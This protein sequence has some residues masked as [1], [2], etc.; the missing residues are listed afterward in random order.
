M[1][2]TVEI[3]PPPGI[4]VS[5]VLG[6]VHMWHLRGHRSNAVD[7][8]VR[9]FSAIELLEARKKLTSAV[10]A[11]AD[12][13][14]SR[15]DSDHRSAAEAHA[16]DLLDQFVELD[17]QK[18]LPVIV[19]PSTQLAKVPVST[20]LTSDDVAVSARLE[21]LEKS[22]KLLSD[23]VTSKMSGL[24]TGMFAGARAR[25]NS[26]SGGRG[27]GQ[28]QEGLQGPPQIS[29]TPPGGLAGV[30]S[31]A[32]VANTG[33]AGFQGPQ[34]VG[35]GRVGSDAEKRK[36]EGDQNTFRVPGRQ[37]GRKVAIGKSTVA[38]DDGGE[39]A[40]LEYYVGNTTP[41][42]SPDIIKAVLV[43]CA[44]E[45]QTELQ[46][47]EVTCLTYGLDN[48]R[49]KSWKVKVPYKY[50]ELMEKNE[51]YPE[52]WTYRKFF[53]PRTSS[54]GTGGA[55]KKTRTDDNLVDEILLDL[56][57]PAQA[58]AQSPGQEASTAS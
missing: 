8:I 22:M 31:W 10:G 7:L 45:L 55:I 16:I 1:T 34:V 39:A 12:L 19:V 14:V 44:A 36:W 26:N 53:A 38:V 3:P 27:G 52:G 23:T 33:A 35:R 54:Q 17:R 21:N 58:A 49:T 28:G 2:E 48:P 20:L 43:K 11:D 4:L 25:V 47:I 37:R 24:A 56:D 50:K 29:V 5:L 32:D 9:H 18:K 57:R 30:A 6:T 46:V 42:A 13:V 51:L 41:R 40:P 15:R